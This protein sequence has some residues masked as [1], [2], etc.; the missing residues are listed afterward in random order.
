MSRTM[1]TLATSVSFVYLGLCAA[2][3]LFQRSLIYF[4]QPRS[5]DRGAVTITLQADGAEVL[6]TTR[7]H[8]GPNT[9][10]YFGGNAADA[11]LSPR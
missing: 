11:Y 3:F 1:L 8:S 2:L 7:P 5:L 6:V 4:P 10:V 9:L